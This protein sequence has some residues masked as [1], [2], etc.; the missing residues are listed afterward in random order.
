[1]SAIAGLVAHTPFLAADHA[2]EAMLSVIKDPQNTRSDT[3]REG[4]TALGAN[5]PPGGKGIYSDARLAVVCDARLDNRHDLCLALGLAS[6]GMSDAA[7]I[8]AAFERWGDACP[9]KLT[10]EFAFALWERASRTL[11]CARDRFGIRP[12]YFRNTARSFRFGST[13]HAVAANDGLSDLALDKTWIVDFAAGVLT[14]V[15]YT[16]YADIRR[17]PPAHRL[18]L[19][20]GPPSIE[21]YWSF[22][23]VGPILDGLQPEALR[24]ALSEAVRARMPEARAASFLSG[25]LDSSSLSCLARDT[26]AGASQ[27]GLTAFSI[28]FDETPEESERPYM[29]A[30]LAGG[31][32]TPTFI[33][34]PDYRPLASLSRLMDIQ[35][36]PFL[37][38]GLPLMDHG[39]RAV[40]SQGFAAVLDGHGGD[41]VISSGLGRLHELARSRAWVQLY[42][43][44]SAV[45]SR[46]Q[47]NPLPI[48]ASYVGYHGKGIVARACRRLLAP[49]RGGGA[50]ATA[51]AWLSA[52]WLDD[53]TTQRHA[54]QRRSDAKYFDSDRAHHVALLS[55]PLQAY[56][57]EVISHLTRAHG[58]ESRFPFWDQ[59]V[60]ELC[61]RFP[62]SAKLA[63]GHTRALIRSAMRGILPEAVRQRPDKLD[64]SVHFVSG[65]VRDR[66]MLRDIAASDTA[67]LDRYINRA[68]FAQ[69]LDQ[70]DHPDRATRAAA[71]GALWRG[72][73][74]AIWFAERRGHKMSPQAPLEA[75]E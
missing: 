19:A 53:T 64:F 23:E 36:G 31:G 74:L 8:A 73:A 46:Q 52:P 13:P 40:A 6:A 12:F 66:A 34:I 24:H 2:A 65:L 49:K 57:F 32:I 58:L 1:M 33:S 35:G 18:K 5:P 16:S 68:A 17:L 20:G 70:L 63:D 71:G 50:T 42:R 30:V 56:G 67:V 14:N 44:I 45:A 55:G 41:E 11:F 9:E 61:L 69:F 28:V 25:G 7:V 21:R 75:R 72:A 15:D 48:F 39:Y 37:A 51:P 60:V 54:L 43:E 29:E 22:D 38:P 4:P 47:Q 3:W 10:G 27:S 26:L 62:S 59:R